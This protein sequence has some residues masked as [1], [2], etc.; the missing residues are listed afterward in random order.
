MNIKDTLNRFYEK[1]KP[2]RI[3]Y[4][5]SSDEEINARIRLRDA[6]MNESLKYQEMIDR[7]IMEKFDG[8]KYEGQ[9][10][11]YYD[12]GEDYAI[13]YIKCTKVERLIYGIKI[14]GLIYTIYTDGRL[15]IDMTNTSSVIVNYSDID[16]ELEI[17]SEEEYTKTITATVNNI[18]EK[19]LKH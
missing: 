14:K 16:E 5:C 15:D 1:V 19:F 3:D 18:Y 4:S 7:K 12:G 9:Y 8:L 2:E 11:K 13:S 6:F 17:I 10:I